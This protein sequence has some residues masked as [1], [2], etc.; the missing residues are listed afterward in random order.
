VTIAEICPDIKW[1]KFE[2]QLTIGKHIEVNG[3][4]NPIPVSIVDGKPVFSA[5]GCRIQWAAENGYTEIDAVSVAKNEMLDV[6][7][8]MRSIELTF[9]PSRLIEDKTLTANLE[10]LENK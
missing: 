3:L 8:E 10:A 9:L 6:M 5:G 7:R 2:R 4:I 1:A